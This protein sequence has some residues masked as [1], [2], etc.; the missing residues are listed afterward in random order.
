[1]EAH[2]RS[3]LLD[4]IGIPGPFVWGY[5]GLQ[6]FMIGDGVET[7]FLSR[8]FLDLGLDQFQVGAIF[9][10]YGVTAAIGAY[11]AG[12]L[13]DLW[14]PRK[15]MATGAAIW[16]VLH[17]VMLTLAL[18]TRNYAL[19]VASYGLRSFGYPL[20]AYGL[21]IWLIAGS[22]RERLNTALGWFWCCFTAGYPV[23]GSL[24]AAAFLPALHAAGLLWLSWCLVAC[25]AAI[26]LLLIAE[27]TGR[28]PLASPEARDLKSI[29]F[30]GI[31]VMFTT[32]A[33]GRGAIARVI[34]TTSQFGMWVFFPIFFTQQLHLPLAQ[35]ATLLSIMM[36]ANMAAVILVG[37]ISD[38]WSWRKATALFGGVFCALA[39]VIFY[40]VLLVAASNF[41][42]IAAAAALYGVAVASYVALPPMMTAQ[43]PDR[44]GQVMAAYSLG[45]R[46]LGSG[47]PARRHPVHRPSGAAGRGMDLCSASPAIG[48]LCLSIK[49]PGD[50]RP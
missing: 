31:T 5:L 35:W 30:N 32:P 22:A 1:M 24:L 14:G 2:A 27:R 3:T 13:S 48:F 33:V 18:P 41:M 20:F 7:S 28:R 38:R 47:G 40:Y 26:A 39:C 50:G 12:A 36:G 11:L 8:L 43:A 9:T 49:S 25:G 45:A 16:L 15:V 29:L 37:M 42:A 23:I 4:R 34:D 10:F 44:Q 19:L 6:L 17:L 46:G 21:M